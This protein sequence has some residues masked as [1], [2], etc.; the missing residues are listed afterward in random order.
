MKERKI[1]IPEK[2]M[3]IEDEK[4]ICYLLSSVLT[5]HN[6]QCACVYSITEAKENI[7]EIKPSIVFLDNHLSDG[8]GSDIIP[9]IKNIYPAAKIIMITAYDAHADMNIAFNKGADYFISKPF[10]SEN[11]KKTINLIKTHRA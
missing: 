11:I 5:Q 6:L 8:Y 10:N 2:V 9:M 3:I 4:D 1:F 7:R